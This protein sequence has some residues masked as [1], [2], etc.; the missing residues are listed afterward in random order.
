MK[1]HLLALSF[2]FLAACGGSDATQKADVQAEKATPA[3]KAEAAEEKPAPPPPKPEEKPET[4]IV[5]DDGSVATVNLTANDAMKFNTA[6]I[7]IAAGRTVKLTL[8]HVGKM[9]VEMMGH[10]FVLLAEG[11]DLAAFSAAGVTAKDTD[12]IADSMKDKVLA[13]TKLI[14]GGASDSIEFAAPA[15]GTYDFLCTFPGHSAI[16][17][18][19]LIV[20]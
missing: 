3:A 5:V 2:V 15:P 16:M 12:Y 17:K 6:E 14:G 20:S 18:G 9:P 7:K 1:L 19:K 11:T 10:N 13:Q 8:K 4:P